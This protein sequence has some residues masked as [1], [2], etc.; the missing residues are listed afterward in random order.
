MTKECDRNER[1]MATIVVAF[2][3]VRNSRRALERVAELAGEG[4]RVV[5][6]GSVEAAWT[7]NRLQFEPE[8]I[9]E[10]RRSL[11]EA[12]RILF[13]LGVGARTMLGRG[14]EASVLASVASQNAARLIVIGRPRTVAQRIGLRLGVARLERLAP[15]PVVRVR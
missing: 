8:E 12:R 15:C 6:V 2:D 7:G 11:D 10:R 1:E 9:E 5:V 13:Q 14:R 3:G 4:D